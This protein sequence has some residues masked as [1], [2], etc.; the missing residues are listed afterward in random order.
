[1]KS[2]RRFSSDIS[3]HGDFQEGMKFFECGDYNKALSFLTLIDIDALGES[4]QN[5]YLSYLGLVK[6]C[7]GEH[8]G[9]KLCRRA[10]HLERFNGDV[11]H[12]LACAELKLNERR[13]A[14]EILRSGLLIEPNHPGLN[15]MHNKM[16]SRKRPVMR[17][18]S[19]DNPVNRVIGKIRHSSP[20]KKTVRKF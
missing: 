11:Y 5:I 20:R 13:S 14:M 16:C 10:V 7:L 3:I 17:F 9:I 4:S 2:T 6:V 12:N 1:M 18:L 8:E 15:D 19:R